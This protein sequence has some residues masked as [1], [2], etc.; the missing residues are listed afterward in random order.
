MRAARV[1]GPDASAAAARIAP[2][3]DGSVAT[4]ERL[5]PD[6]PR[7]PP[8]AADAAYGL[9]PDGSWVGAGED[10]TVADLVDVAAGHDYL[11]VVGV[12]TNLPA[13]VVGDGE[14]RDVLVRADAAEALDVGAVADALDGLDPRETLGSLVAGITSAPGSDRAGAVATFTGRVRAKDSA[15]EA[16]TERLE[17]EKYEGVA[18]E[19][20]ATIERELEDREGVVAVRTHHR[21]GVVEAGEDIVHVV[22]LAGHRREAFRAVEDGIDRLKDEVPLFKKEVTVEDEFWVHERE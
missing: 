7:T 5:E 1:V 4:V 12:E 22:V 20:M 13:V 17:F 18:D 2:A 21:T 19:R 14:A 3:L 10:R 6:A 15:D 11:L 8:P 9:A 16:R